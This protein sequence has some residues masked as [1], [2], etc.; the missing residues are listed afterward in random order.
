MSKTML[1]LNAGS[2]SIKFGLF[3][4]TGAE[5]S[6]CSQARSR[7]SATSR[8]SRSRTWTARSV[9]DRD[10]PAPRKQEDILHDIL[11]WADQK[12]GKRRA[13]RDRTSHRAW[14]IA[15]CRAGAVESGDDRRTGTPDADGASAPGGLSVRRPEPCCRFVL[16]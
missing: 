1:V 12:A 14:R 13:R 11:G 4:M 3:D 6:I 2:S 9:L 7:I 5:P 15:I 8:T 16:I 10:W